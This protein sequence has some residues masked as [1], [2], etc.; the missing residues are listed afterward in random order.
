MAFRASL[1]VIRE[2]LA[3][4]HRRVPEQGASTLED[5]RAKVV[6][7]RVAGGR[8]GRLSEVGPEDRVGCVLGHET[9]VLERRGVEVQDGFDTDSGGC[10]LAA[11]HSVLSIHVPEGFEIFVVQGLAEEG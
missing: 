5:R 4:L 1:I 6:H 10:S 7:V 9:F 2:L 8:C 11:E 3:E